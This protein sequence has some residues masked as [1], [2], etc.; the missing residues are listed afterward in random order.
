[1]FLKTIGKEFNHFSEKI[2]EMIHDKR[3]TKT[4]IVEKKDVLSNIIDL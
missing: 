4:R 1:M 3:L 2:N